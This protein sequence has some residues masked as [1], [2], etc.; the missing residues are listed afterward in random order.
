MAGTGVKGSDLI[1]KQSELIMKAENASE[2]EI[3]ANNKQIEEINNIVTSGSMEE[4][5]SA[6]EEA[7]MKNYNDLTDEEKNSITD[8]DEYIKTN[9]DRDLK[10]YGTT[11][12]KFF[13]AYDPAPV[14]EKVK[15]PVLMLFGE[16]DLQVPPAQ[17]K[18][19][20]ENA[21]QKGGNKDYMSVVFPKANH[22]FLTAT[23]GSPEEYT[24]LA[25]EFVPD[26]LTTIKE[27][28]IK[29]VTVVE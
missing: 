13:M 5:R 9:V 20:M 24:S 21:L 10:R 18:A 22:L 1:T 23:T 28:I 7:E 26:F 29:R 12:F 27:W 11:W 8:K 17:N 14:L 4:L 2:E 25:K 15:C 3:R 6:F 19:P 16:L